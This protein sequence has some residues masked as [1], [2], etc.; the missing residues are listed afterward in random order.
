MVTLTGAA[1]EAGAKQTAVAASNTGS[2]AA[3]EAVIILSSQSLSD[4]APEDSSRCKNERKPK[5]ELHLP[6]WSSQ[7]SSSQSSWFGKDWNKWIEIDVDKWSEAVKGKEQSEQ[8]PKV[9]R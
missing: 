8:K 7:S 9:E 1:A 6:S 3:E 4:P 2:T 5:V